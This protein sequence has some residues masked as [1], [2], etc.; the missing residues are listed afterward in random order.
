MPTNIELKARIRN[1]PEQRRYV[2]ALA[3][4]SSEVFD[5]VDT[6]FHVPHGRLKLRESKPG[7]A[8]L[9]FYQRANQAAVKKSVYS[10]IPIDHPEELGHALAE[11]LGIAGVVRKTRRLYLVGQTRIHWDEVEGLGEF[12]ELEVV[13]HP[14]QADEDGSRIAGE[15]REQL[16]IYDE[17]LIAG[18]YVD[19]LCGKKNEGR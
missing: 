15:L 14:G 12:L 6:F 13:L 19:L 10:R 17:D 8:E 11:A 9:I 4:A 3:G 5:Q 2:E 1:A 18:A 16:G 7:G